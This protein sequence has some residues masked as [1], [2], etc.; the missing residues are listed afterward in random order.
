VKK[1]ILLVIILLFLPSNSVALSCAKPK[2][3]ED[4]LRFSEL[5]FKGELIDNNR[6]ENL[7]ANP[8]HA[9]N[10]KPEV[11]KVIKAFKGV[12][13]NEEITIF[14]NVYWGDVSKNGDIQLVTTS[15]I[16]GGR[17]GVSKNIYIAPYCK[18]TGYY[19]YD[20]HSVNLLKNYFDE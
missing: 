14:R 11:F 7:V 3:S 10:L 8:F 16:N 1:I 18:A 5:V 4:I 6:D 15:K 17:Y 12:K 2:L 20:H 19:T 13:K 9:N